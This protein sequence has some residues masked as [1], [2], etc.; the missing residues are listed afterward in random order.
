MPL[1][2]S[3]PTL[4]QPLTLSS[5]SSSLTSLTNSNR[6]QT[7]KQ[8]Q[9]QYNGNNTLNSP[10]QQHSGAKKK[11]VERKAE[12]ITR[13]TDDQNASQ[14][15]LTR[16]GHSIVFTTLWIIVLCSVVIFNIM[17]I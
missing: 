6:N 7:I 11:K 15:I 12:K 5:S 4:L 16:L 1:A 13:E 10:T 9:Q 17:I 2:F 8:Q 3:A 14:V